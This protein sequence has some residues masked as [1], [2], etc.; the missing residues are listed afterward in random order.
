MQVLLRPGLL[1]DVEI[2]VEKIPNAVYVSSQAV[3]E[4]EGKFVV[5][6]KSGAGFE[7]RQVKLLKRSESTVVIS[8]GVK[9][10]EP[11]ALADP[12]AKKGGKQQQEKP[13]S[14]PSPMGVPGGARS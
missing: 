14:G 10:G 1:A 11:V 6:V 8:E 7:E 5:F 12:T 2:T 3:F 9:P 4:K 13:E